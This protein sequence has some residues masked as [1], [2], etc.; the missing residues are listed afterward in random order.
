MA[1]LLR[2]DGVFYLSVP[3]GMARVE[4]N[5]KRVFDPRAV[6]KLAQDNYLQLCSLTVIKQGGKVMEFSLDKDV[7]M[8]ELCFREWLDFYANLATREIPENM[9]DA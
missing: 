9:L 8:Q 3:I 4:F 2:K 6:I 7:R 1:S 5:A